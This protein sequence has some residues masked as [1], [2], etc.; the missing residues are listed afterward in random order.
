[1]KGYLGIIES[2]INL[3]PLGNISLKI[4]VLLIP[5]SVVI[6][7]KDKKITIMIVRHFGEGP[8]KCVCQVL[9]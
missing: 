3:E 2:P 1:M 9:T 4:R 8:K 6:K 5:Q 7:N